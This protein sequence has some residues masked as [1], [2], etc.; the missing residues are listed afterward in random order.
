MK[1]KSQ[2]HIERLCS[3]YENSSSGALAAFDFLINITGL[4]NLMIIKDLK[5]KIEPVEL[6]RNNS[7]ANGESLRDLICITQVPIA[8][9]AENIPLRNINQKAG[10]PSNRE[11]RLPTKAL[12][13]KFYKRPG[14]H[15]I[16][17]SDF[18]GGNGVCR[19]PWYFFFIYPPM[20]IRTKTARK[21]SVHYN[22]QI[23]LQPDPE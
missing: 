20:I 21:T 17:A 7:E 12:N 23:S 4:R 8:P 11:H 2:K 18:L 6:G 19:H 13:G 9:C 14:R 3:W 16:V 22:R 1:S 10:H 15:E 5:R